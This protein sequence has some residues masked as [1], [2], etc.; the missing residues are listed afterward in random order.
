MGARACLAGSPQR[1]FAVTSS[2]ICS[3]GQAASGALFWLFPRSRAPARA[4]T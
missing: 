1:L 3:P 4:C 2:F